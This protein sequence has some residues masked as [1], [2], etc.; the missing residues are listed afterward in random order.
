MIPT[1]RLNFGRLPVGQ[2]RCC[3]SLNIAPALPPYLRGCWIPSCG[4]VYTALRLAGYPLLV[5]PRWLR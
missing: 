3:C 5:L 2:L 4:Y 1:L